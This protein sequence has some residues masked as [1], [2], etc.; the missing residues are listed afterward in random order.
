MRRIKLMPAIVFCLVFLTLPF[1]F[2]QTGKIATQLPQKIAAPPSYYLQGNL[3]GLKAYVMTDKGQQE[4]P[5]AGSIVLRL[6]PVENTFKISISSLNLFAKGINTAKGNSGTIGLSIASTAEAVFNRSTG[7]ISIPIQATLHY[8][9]IDK[10]KGFRQSEKSREMDNFVPFTEIMAGV[11]NTRLPKDLRIQERSKVTMEAQINIEVVQQV[12]GLFPKMMFKLQSILELLKG[13]AQVLKIQPV[14]VGTGPGDA[15]ATGKAFNTLKNYA[16]SNWSKC[17]TVRCVSLVFNEPIYVNKPAYRILDNS[18]EASSFMAEV[19]VTD[20]VEIFVAEKLSSSLTC[21]WGGGATFSS[22]TA[23]AK[24]VTSDEQLG[25]PC[26]CPCP[27]YCPLGPCSCGALNNYH[28]AHEL[29]HAIGLAH[30]GDTGLAPSTAGSVMAASG[31]CNDNPSTQ[32][33]KNCRNA[34]NP[35][36]AAGTAICIS[37]PDIMD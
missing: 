8:E 29:G 33:A 12:V 20:A 7:Q 34:S 21:A 23:S 1:V 5:F 35:L 37:S 14:F 31:M 11:F 26:P 19:S 4:V 3:A 25:V 32:S 16:I 6:T 24:I 10:L 27:T 28:L 2:A 18:T 13:P 17:G 22:G 30:P 36:F 9:M 15:T